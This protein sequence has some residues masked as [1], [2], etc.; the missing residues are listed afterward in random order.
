MIV[1]YLNKDMK[2]QIK[3]IFLL[4]AIFSLFIGILGGFFP[5][6]AQIRVIPEPVSIELKK[7]YFTIDENTAVIF[8]NTEKSKF[9]KLYFGNIIKKVCGYELCDYRKGTKTIMF[10]LQKL[11]TIGEEGYILEVNPSEIKIVA[12]TER[13]L[14]YAVQTIVQQLPAF[15]TNEMVRIP[16]MRVK[17]YPKIAWRG[18]ML[19]VSRHFYGTEEIKSILDLLALYKLNVF[20]WHL[21][22]NEGWR[23][24]IKKYPKL[25]SLASWRQ[26]VNGSIWYAQDSSLNWKDTYQ[27]GGFYTQAEAREIVAYAAARNIMVIP[28]IEMPGHSGAALAAYPQFSCTQLE[29]PVPNSAIFNKFNPTP[30]PNQEYCAGNDSSFRFLEDVLNE[31][32]TIFPSTYIHIGGDEV[33]KTHWKACVK[34]Q[35]RM[36]AENLEHEEQLQ[37]YFIRRMEKFLNAHGRQL[38]GWDEILEGGLAPSATVMSWRGEQ[39]G[40]AAA[41]MGHDVIMSPSNPLY[42]NRYQTDPASEPL[43]AKYSINTLENVYQYNPF[44]LSLD[45]KQHRYIKGVQFALWTEHISSLEQ[46]EYMMLPR[47]AALAEVTWTPFEK[48]NFDLFV[49]RL[50]QWHYTYWTHQGLRFNKLHQR[51]KY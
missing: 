7:G 11:D 42:F 29:Q 18:M 32:F 49:E 38:L 20:H 28:E 48:H 50:N 6:K 37:S 47:L 33:L 19:D 27:Y 10:S 16:A 3:L 25:I 23:I 45:Q 36:K 41:K 15:R 2:K 24:E 30:S 43:A 1:D 51:I 8:P 35:Q 39:G 21:T 17:D 46:L 9:L 14:F 26:E 12:N 44:T 31:I 5:V 22:D 13:G 40:I 34:C 4:R